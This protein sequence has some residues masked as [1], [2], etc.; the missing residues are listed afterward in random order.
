ML[1][2][3]AINGRKLCRNDYSKVG[4]YVQQ[5]DA[6]MEV[7]T[8]REVFEFVCR[9]RLGLDEEEIAERV[10]LLID[11]LELQEC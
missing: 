8:P 7:L 2:D 5:D 11:R 1:G 3:V 10:N 4:A 6:L 9:M